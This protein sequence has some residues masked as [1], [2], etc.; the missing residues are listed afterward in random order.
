[1]HFVAQLR[2][3]TD[4]RHE[5]GWFDEVDLIDAD[6]R[7]NLTLLRRHEQAINEIGFDAGLG[8]AGNNDELVDIGHK[9]VLP[10]TAGATHNPAPRLDALNDSFLRALGSKPHDIAGCHHMPLIGG[11]S[12]QNSSRRALKSFARFVV[13]DADQPLHAEDAAKT[14]HRAINI[15]IH[16]CAGLVFDDFGAGHRALARDV[17][18]ATNTFAMRRV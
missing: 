3:H 18:F 16:V 14:A 9:H 2:I 4:E 11:Q 13:H 12:F 1:M 10:P 15:Q 7:S 5:I 8:R 6:E 17:S